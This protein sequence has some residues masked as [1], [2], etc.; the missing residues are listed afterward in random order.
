MSS[1]PMLTP[2][3]AAAVAEREAWVDAPNADPGEMQSPVARLSGM[4][5]SIRSILHLG[6]GTLVVLLVVG[7]GIGFHALRSMSREVTA[8]F[9]TVQEQSALSSRLTADIAQQ[10]QAATVYLD[11]RDPANLAEIRA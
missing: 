1:Q 9:A 10:H 8:S 6:F 11:T 7:G 5:S 3:S 4:F 2:R